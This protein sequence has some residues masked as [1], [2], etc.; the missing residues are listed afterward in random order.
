MIYPSFNRFIALAGL[1]AGII[2]LTG[3]VV[4][5]YGVSQTQLKKLTAAQTRELKKNFI[6]I[7]KQRATEKQAQDRL[8]ITPGTPKLRL[9]IEGGTVVMPPYSSSYAYKPAT[10]TV[11]QG[12]CQSVRLLQKEGNR[13]TDLEACYL[14]NILY[15]DPSR[16][17]YKWIHGSLRFYYTPIWQSGFTYNDISSQGY[18]L[19]KNAKIKVKAIVP[20]TRSH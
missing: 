15:L 10:L 11:Y 1:F 7:Q 12:K 16:Y 8:I 19:L 18:T 17:E 14:G 4:G 2:S 20:P 13:S 3:C 5:D 9:S 6:R